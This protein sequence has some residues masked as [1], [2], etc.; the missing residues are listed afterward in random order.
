MGIFRRNDDDVNDTY[1]EFDYDDEQDEIIEKFSSSSTRRSYDPN[2]SARPAQQP[3]QNQPRQSVPSPSDA[4]AQQ[5]YFGASSR[6][7]STQSRQT[8]TQPSGTSAK[9]NDNRYRSSS[10]PFYKVEPNQQHRRVEELYIATLSKTND[11][12]SVADLIKERRYALII[13]INPLK[14]QDNKAALASV[15]NF[16]DGVC[17]V[18]DSELK[19]IVKGCGIYLIYH[20]DVILNQGL[21]SSYQPSG[22]K[23]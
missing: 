5:S 17:Y 13:D 15:I 9:P 23:Y 2:R 6:N 3:R 18:T 4:R 21:G 16:I 1:D 20:R 10:A 7:N 22:Y 14:S 19:E 12:M 8:Y 11:A